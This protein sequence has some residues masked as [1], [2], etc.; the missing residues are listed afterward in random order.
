MCTLIAFHRCFADAPLVVAAN[1]DEFLERPTEGPALREASISSSR[2]TGRSGRGGASAR[3][4]RVVAP[5]DLRAGGSWLGV[6]ASGLF[7]AIT[8]RRCDSP[9]PSRRSRGW[10]VMEALAEPSAERAA[11]RFARLPGDAYNPFNLFVA[12]RESAHVVTYSD[13]PQR[14]DLTAGPHVV[15]NVHPDEPSRKLDWLR[16]RVADLARGEVPGEEALAGLCR[17]HVADAPLESPCVHAGGYG[18]RSSTLLWI[19]A[20]PALRYAEGPPCAAPYRDLTPLLHD[21]GLFPARER[22]SA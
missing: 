19:G 12:D 14:R 21:L 4:T 10:L 11:E 1:R 9:D 18:T 2:R 3:A 8:N 15:G 22:V 5:R 6:N 7:A 16:G 20:Q 17:T 13:R